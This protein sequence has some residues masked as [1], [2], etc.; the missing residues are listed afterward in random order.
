M[1]WKGRISF[2]YAELHIQCPKTRATLKQ[3]CFACKMAMAA[4][5]RVHASETAAT[6]PNMKKARVSCG[7][8]EDT[9]GSVKD[10]VKG[11]GEPQA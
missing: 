11:P 7:G 6:L 8:I 10:S 4:E 1:P 5:T 9:Q 2:E 3:L